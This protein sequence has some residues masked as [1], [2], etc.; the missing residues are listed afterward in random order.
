MKQKMQYFLLKIYIGI[1]F[2]SVYYLKISMNLLQILLLISMIIVFLEYKLLLKN[3]RLNTYMW[4]I[5]FFLFFS[6]ILNFSFH[7]FMYTIANIFTILCCMIIIK[8]YE[9][10]I[11][12]I[13]Y[14]YL[15]FFSWIN[16]I[17]LNFFHT[18]SSDAKKIFG[19]T[20]VRRAS[21]WVNLSAVST[22]AALLLIISIFL[23][24]QKKSVSLLLNIVLSLWLIVISGKINIFISLFLVIFLMFYRK[25]LKRT[26]IIVYT[27]EFIL[28]NTSWLFL[29]LKKNISYFIDIPFIL[30][31]RDRLWKDYLVYIYEHPHKL[32][33][34][35]NF[36]QEDVSYINHPH[37]QYLMILYIIGLGGLIAYSIVFYNVLKNTYR[38]NNMLFYLNI[39]IF[40]LMTGDD[41][42]V[43]TVYPITF[44]IILSGLNLKN[45]EYKI[46]KKEITSDG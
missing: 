44:L 37:N 15:I 14:K 24:K 6:C 22:W 28:I 35:S 46:L 21:D 42:F 38:K 13:I 5:I 36:F 33:I 26:L 32:I 18:T 16:F 2:L 4:S 25:I 29:F 27:L 1:S 17:L 7:N 20:I 30:T 34:G 9:M 40:I 43:L 23:L 8:K 11:V 39:V 12:P 41:Y 3:N 31:G 45:K 19:H 10:N